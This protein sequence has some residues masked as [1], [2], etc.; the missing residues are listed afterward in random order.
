MRLFIER[1]PEQRSVR[2]RA[3]SKSLSQQIALKIVNKETGLDW[4]MK[5]R[6]PKILWHRNDNHYIAGG[7]THTI[8]DFFGQ[9]LHACYTVSVICH[10][11]I[12][13][14]IICYFFGT[15]VTVLSRCNILCSRYEMAE[16]EVLRLKVVS[17]LTRTALR[18]DWAMSQTDRWV[19]ENA[20]MQVPIHKRF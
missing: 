10:Y 5:N 20:N 1:F 19:N 11:F 13:F 12:C 3:V 4:L 18:F 14:L 17:A 9:K 16:N 6:C 8:F 2:T 7:K 15:R